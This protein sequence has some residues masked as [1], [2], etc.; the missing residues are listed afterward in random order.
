[1][2][3]KKQRMLLKMNK[4]IRYFQSYLSTVKNLS[5]TTIY[6]YTNDIKA[7]NK[8]LVEHN[9]S[10]FDATNQD[11]YDFLKTLNLKSNSYNRKITTF[12]EFYKYLIYE[13]YTINVIVDK[14]LHIK[15]DKKFPRIISFEDVGK[16]I[17]VQ[18]NSLLG[19]RNKAIIMLLYISGLRVSELCNLTFN[20]INFEEGYIRCIGK[21]NKE[22]II[23]CGDLL[24]ITLNTYVNEI[25]MKIL[26]GISSK[27]IF[28]NQEGDPLKRQTIYNVVKDAAS[29]A[30]IKLKV[31]PHTLRHCFATHMLE[32]GADIRS[33]QEML[34]H[35][36]ISTTQIYL[37][38]S[39]KTLKENY[40]SKFKDP[41]K[42][43]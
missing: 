43:D 3:L 1:M 23:V 5:N 9:L 17:K 25:R 36:D 14:L 2:Y 29:K 31:S 37:N 22:K 33:V 34:G 30:N 24:K 18:D 6:N 41:L 27:Y 21:G 32:N 38:I 4:E 26:Y 7:L 15:N 12:K 28:V 19:E 20:N 11:I 8:H 10:L 40:Y 35:S 42:E 16:L 39:K 13:N